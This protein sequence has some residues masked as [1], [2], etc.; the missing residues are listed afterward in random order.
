M[1]SIYQKDQRHA[2]ACANGPKG[3][4]DTGSGYVKIVDV[5]VATNP[6]RRTLKPL[7]SS[8]RSGFSFDTSKQKVVSYA[9]S[10]ETRLAKKEGVNRN[11]TGS[12]EHLIQKGS[13]K[14]ATWRSCGRPD[15]A[16]KALAL[17]FQL[18]DGARIDLSVPFKDANIISFS[19]REWLEYCAPEFL[20]SDI[21]GDNAFPDTE[22]VVD[23]S[24]A[25]RLD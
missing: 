25:D 12:H 23:L 3:C 14:E 7:R 13:L 17:S 22:K 8:H 21:D 10:L 15:V 20:L 24:P 19:I 11:L 2:L 18:A 6:L 16:K 9:M 1:R 5:G 4:G